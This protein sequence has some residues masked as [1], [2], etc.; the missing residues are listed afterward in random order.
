M[1]SFGFCGSGGCAMHWTKKPNQTGFHPAHPHPSPPPSSPSLSSP[2]CLQRYFRQ[3]RRSQSGR[4]SFTRKRERPQDPHPNTHRTEFSVGGKNQVDELPERIRETDGRKGQGTA[5][6][7][8]RF[9]VQMQKTM[10]NSYTFPQSLKKYMGKR[11]K[12]G[13]NE[14]K[15][16]PIQTMFYRNE[17]CGTPDAPWTSPG[18]GGAAGAGRASVPLSPRRC[19]RNPCRAPL[20]ENVGVGASTAEN[21]I[22]SIRIQ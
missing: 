13:I 12:H 9:S 20:G 22:R 21:S 8:W 3:Y 19:P 11:S 10:R 1:F 2:S 18:G 14:E 15:Y 5:R 17:L 16:M 4:D 7:A 6:G